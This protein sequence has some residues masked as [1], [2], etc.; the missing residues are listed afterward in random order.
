MGLSFTCGLMNHGKKNVY[1]KPCLFCEWKDD[2][3]EAQKSLGKKAENITV[4]DMAKYPFP[5]DDHRNRRR[6]WKSQFIKAN[7][8]FFA[9][10]SRDCKVEGHT[11]IISRDHFSS[12][13][14]PKLH[15]QK[16]EVKI[17]FYDIMIEIAR[18]LAD[19]TKDTQ[20]AK[21]YIMSMCEHWTPEELEKARTDCS[22]EHLH[23]H[24]LP[25]KK[26]MRTPY[27]YYVPESMFVRCDVTQCD[28]QLERTRQK[29]LGL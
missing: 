5:T 18:N 19:F 7:E 22:T 16:N 27:P 8:H 13:A 14:D 3:K 15:N 6:P 20:T 4:N 29:I 2:L 11:L 28:D 25:R 17:A 10:L 9:V 24:L 1:S 21:V 12:I 26:A 23:F